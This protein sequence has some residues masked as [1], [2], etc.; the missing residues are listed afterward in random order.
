MT[1]MLVMTREIK[2]KE[3]RNH[4]DRNKLLRVLGTAGLE[5]RYEIAKSIKVN[6]HHAFLLCT[7]GFW[8]LVLEEEM[9]QCLKKAKSPEEW[10]SNMEKILLERGK[11]KPMDNY[12]AIGVWLGG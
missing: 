5:P 8:D 10:L 11:D 2:E 7:D 12:S 9:Q 1:Q 6:K 3:I 4:P